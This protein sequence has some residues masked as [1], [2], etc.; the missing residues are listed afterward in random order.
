M[1]LGFDAE[2]LDALEKR[3]WGDI[4]EGADPATAAQH[5]VELRRYGP[6]QATVIADLPGAAW[7]NLVLGSTAPGAVDQGHLDAALDWADSLGIAYYVP[8]TPGMP[9]TGAAEKRLED[10]GLEH[11]Y[12]WMKFV[13]DSAAP[14]L[15][16]PEG[17]EVV[18]LAAGEGQDFAS[19][20]AGGFGLPA[21]AAALFSTLPGREGWHCYVALADG[22]PAASG[23]MRVEGGEAEFG[24]AATLERARGRGCQLALLRRRIQDGIAAGCRTLFVETGER[25]PDRP[26]GSYRNILR[27]GFVEAYLRPNW[28]R[29]RS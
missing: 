28:Q 19:I 14:E 10:R 4:W 1:E 22:V 29:P 8:V 6:V 5:G 3:L 9:G 17:V 27:A 11:G 25:V 26:S 16:E 21:W 20:V 23:A 7:L 24:L 2:P 12:A 18:E 13:H 15:P